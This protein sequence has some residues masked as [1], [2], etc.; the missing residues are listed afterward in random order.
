MWEPL[1]TAGIG[2][3]PGLQYGTYDTDRGICDSLRAGTVDAFQ[4]AR[5]EQVAANTE[6]GRRIA[7]MIPLICSDQQAALNEALG[8][9]PTMRTFIG[10]KAFVA[11][12]YD[13][14]KS[15]V[16]P[17]TWK[18]GTVS[19]CYWER[20]DDQGN[21]IEN[22]MVSLAESIVVTI[23]ETDAAFNSQACGRWTRAE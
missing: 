18:T 9:R 10:G 19:D 15:I 2:F 1:T 21:I 7:I 16:Q 11:W 20:L 12:E 4:L 22:N 3:R 5:R 23:A 14:N 17:G 13:P 6:N 8:P